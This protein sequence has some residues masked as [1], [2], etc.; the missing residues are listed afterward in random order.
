MLR[1]GITNAQK[2]VDATYKA[3]GAL[4]RGMGVQKKVSAGIKMTA[5][6]SA[7]TEDGIFVV[8]RDN[9]ASG[10]D[11][12]YPDRPDTAYDNIASG[13]LVK[14]VPYVFGE[15][16]YTDQYDE[17]ISTGDN[18]AVGTDGKWEK[19]ASGGTK[20]VSRGIITEAGVTYLVIEVVA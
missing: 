13:E 9:L 1:N 11:C 8:D 7:A 14:L 12:A 10:I 15:T 18:V 3:H 16:F 17:G 19:L 4:K 20:Y 6:P 2:A 5:F